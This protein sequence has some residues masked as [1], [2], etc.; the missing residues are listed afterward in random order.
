MGALECSE[1]EEATKYKEWRGGTLRN[2]TWKYAVSLCVSKLCSI[3][4]YYWTYHMMMHLVFCKN[5]YEWTRFLNL[6]IFRIVNH[7]SLL[8]GRGRWGDVRRWRG[9]LSLFVT[10]N[11]STWTRSLSDIAIVLPPDLPW[12]VYHCFVTYFCSL[13]WECTVYTVWPHWSFNNVC[14]VIVIRFVGI[15]LQK[16]FE[17]NRSGESN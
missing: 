3:G 17:F 1:L 13:H 2:D 16:I 8:L 9:T 15:E 7:L 10:T 5:E 12:S 4:L 14:N 11:E 6:F